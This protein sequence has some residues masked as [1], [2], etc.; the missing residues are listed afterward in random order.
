MAKSNAGLDPVKA[1]NQEGTIK[2]G[3]AVRDALLSV[4]EGKADQDTALVGLERQIVELSA[5]T[6]NLLVDADPEAV[7]AILSQAVAQLWESIGSFDAQNGTQ[8]VSEL[9]EN[10][11]EATLAPA[12]I[13]G[14]TD[15]AKLFPATF[16]QPANSLFAQTVVSEIPTPA[17]RVEM[18]SLVFAQTQPQADDAPL[19]AYVTNL[20]LQSQSPMQNGQ[21]P[22]PTAQVITNASVIEGIELRP[23]ATSDWPQQ[24]QQFAVETPLDNNVARQLITSLAD[25]TDKTGAVAMQLSGGEAIKAKVKELL[26]ISAQTNVS[27]ANTPISSDENPSQLLQTRTELQSM[28]APVLPEHTRPARSFSQNIA[29]QIQGRTI[30][31][32]ITRI[33]LSPRGLGNVIIEL[34]T[35]ETGDIQIVVKAENPAVLHALRT[36]REMLLSI[37]SNEVSAQDGVDL[38]FEEFSDGQFKHHEDGVNGGEGPA[39]SELENEDT[40]DLIDPASAKQQLLGAGQ[41]NILT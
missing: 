3:E 19:F 15:I 28:N 1:Q 40:E 21:K 16:I 20:L 24:I 10:L 18:Q 30:N 13:Q 34:Q 29:S 9:S 27:N 35:K 33:E 14:T 23:K 2:F 8:L 17:G 37:L 26:A 4:H 25:T 6:E 41:L 36:D 38:E 7:E 22:G 11:T 31:E 39:Q 5:K 32:G 12:D